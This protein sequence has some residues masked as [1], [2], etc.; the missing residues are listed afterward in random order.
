MTKRTTPMAAIDQIGKTTPNVIL[1]TVIINRGNIDL[2][3]HI[4]EYL[5]ADGTG[6][7]FTNDNY[8]EKLQIRIKVKTDRG[9]AEA[10]VSSANAEIDL[11]KTGE[12]QK[13]YYSFQFNMN[14]SQGFRDLFNLQSTTPFSC[15][16][17]TVSAETFISR[18]K[19]SPPINFGPIPFVELGGAMSSVEVVKDSNAQ[20]RT[21]GYF[22]GNTFY[23]GPKTQLTNGRWVTGNARDESSEFLIERNVPNIKVMDNRDVFE[24]GTEIDSLL[25]STAELQRN[26]P[27]APYFS[28]LSSTRDTNGFLRFLFTFDYRKAYSKNS[29]YGQTF[30]NLSNRLQDRVLLM[31]TLQSL[32]LKRSRAGTSFA[33]LPAETIITSGEESG[34]RFVDINNDHAALKEEELNFQKGTLYLRTFSGVDKV[35]KEISNGEYRYSTDVTFKDGI[36][37]FLSFQSEDLKKSTTILAK[38]IDRLETYPNGTLKETFVEQVKSESDFLNRPY[39]RALVS[40]SENIYFYNTR[41]P[42]KLINSLRSW[43]SPVTGT[44]DSIIAAYRMMIHIQSNLDNLMRTVRNDV[45]EATTQGLPRGNLVYNITEGFGQKFNAAESFKNGL[46]FLSATE[47]LEPQDPDGLVKMTAPAFESRIKDESINFFKSNDVSFDIVGGQDSISSS[48]RTTS[49]TYLTPTAVRLNDQIFAVGT[50]KNLKATEGLDVNSLALGDT[51]NKYKSVLSKLRS[52]RITDAGV[53][54]PTLDITPVSDPSFSPIAPEGEINP[55]DNTVTSIAS[56]GDSIGAESYDNPFDNLKLNKVIPSDSG[57]TIEITTIAGSNIQMTREQL[58]LLPN[59]FKA[60]LAGTQ[61][62]G[63]SFSEILDKAENGDIDPYSLIVGSTVKIEVLV[64]FK[65]NDA[66]RPQSLIREPSWVPLTYELYRNQRGTNLLCKLVKYDNDAIGFKR[67]NDAAVFNHFFVLESPVV[68]DIY[69]DDANNLQIDINGANSLDDLINIF[70]NYGIDYDPDADA[71]DLEVQIG[72]DGCAALV[73]ERMIED[74][75]DDNI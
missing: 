62:F 17:M 20:T 13:I 39:I 75:T 11:S 22:L 73:D 21:V 42:K 53:G 68:S 35:F 26:E 5:Y 15:E 40:L 24:S 43:L 4:N 59:Y 44:R 3:M 29:L 57:D 45:S 67:S 23:T 31:S 38:Y 63:D 9:E 10:Y 49:F 71:S 7:W 74:M 18:D 19:L 28:A 47:I 51:K 72:A 16:E 56:F 37:K 6:T 27:A 36:Y 58:D 41:Q 34:D 32:S 50:I 46:T 64:D 8:K 2:R 30:D 14:E 52:S 48:T 25:V 54:S 65:K 12:Q 66:T 70:S 60:I 69:G 61:V 33:N 55:Q 1:D